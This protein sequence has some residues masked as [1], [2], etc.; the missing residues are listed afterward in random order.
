M[1]TLQDMADFSQIRRRT[2]A[3]LVE[4]LTNA[5][6]ELT[7]TSGRAGRELWSYKDEGVCW[8]RCTLEASAD[9]CLDLGCPESLW[10]N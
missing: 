5:G 10:Q 9:E 4:P 1:E 3:T 8:R 7:T 6:G 2:A